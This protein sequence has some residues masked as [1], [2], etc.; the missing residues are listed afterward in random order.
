MSTI[1]KLSIQGIR[2]F[3]PDQPQARRPT[4][5]VL[6]PAPACV[7]DVHRITGHCFSETADPD[8]G[9]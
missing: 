1:N 8:R 3:S 9:K 4:G 6:L 7:S 5:Q 2:S